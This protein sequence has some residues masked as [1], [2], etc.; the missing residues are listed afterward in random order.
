MV[1]EDFWRFGS[2]KIL[3]GSQGKNWGRD[4]EGLSQPVS[5]T[6]IDWPRPF[7]PLRVGRNFDVHPVEAIKS[8][9]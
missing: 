4:S 9:P 2:P 7:Q 1:T 8:T 5:A 6:R 3:A